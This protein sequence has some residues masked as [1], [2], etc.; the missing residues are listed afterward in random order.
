MYNLNYTPTN[1]GVQSWREIISGGM[2]TK[3]VEYHCSSPPLFHS[4]TT[5]V[6]SSYILH[7]TRL[8]F[9]TAHSRYDHCIPLLCSESHYACQTSQQFFNRQRLL[10]SFSLVPCHLWPLVWAEW[11]SKNPTG[12][13]G[14]EKS[15]EGEA[16]TSWH[17]FPPC[18]Q[19]MWQ[20]QIISKMINDMK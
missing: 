14:V 3:K 11:L 18:S 15:Q 9:I 10:R 20:Y 8:Q 13:R 16:P 5:A 6:S 1:L 19:L 7:W 12:V 2:R 17:A 4:N